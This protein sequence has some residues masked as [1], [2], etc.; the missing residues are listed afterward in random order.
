[1]KKILLL[2]F[3]ATGIQVF[4]QSKK[5]DTTYMLSANWRLKFKTLPFP[6]YRDS[7][8]EIKPDSTKQ[9]HY[10]VLK[11]FYHSSTIFDESQIILVD[12]SRLFCYVIR[13]MEQFYS[14]GY[15]K[16]EVTVINF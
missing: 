3:L 14:A 13:C 10:N 9:L 6:F 4:A 1:M 5:N 2:A 12:S 7:V 8:F 15:Y 11:V 16:K